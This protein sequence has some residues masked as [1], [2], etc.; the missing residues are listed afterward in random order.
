M[1]VLGGVQLHEMPTNEMLVKG[2]CRIL[3]GGS[4]LQCWL[5]GQASPGV[6]VLENHAVWQ[7]MWVRE[8]VHGA[9]RK[10]LGLLV[11]HA[12]F[13]DMYAASRLEPVA[14][15]VWY[16]TMP[17]AAMDRADERPS[18]AFCSTRM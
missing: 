13:A 4:T 12:C 5:C 9:R 8:P 2:A 10:L 14:E 6:T 17:Q 3:S 18:V 1:H 11:R 16:S 7:R 15:L